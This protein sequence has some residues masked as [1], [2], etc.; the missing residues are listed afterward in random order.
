MLSGPLLLSITDALEKTSVYLLSPRTQVRGLAVLS[1]STNVG[2][3]K[4][5][6]A[7]GGSKREIVISQDAQALLFKYDWNCSASGGIG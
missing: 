4:R 3:L 1:A 2:F 6:G 5:N 7:R